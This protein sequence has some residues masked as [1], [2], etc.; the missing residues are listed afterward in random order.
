[1]Q[2]KQT[3]ETKN[4]KTCDI[5][6]DKNKTH[7]VNCGFC[8][9]FGCS[10]CIKKSILYSQSDP[11][12][13]KCN[14][15]WS[16][17]FC[18]EKLTKTFMTKDYPI[19]KKNL[20]FD[21]EKSKI[22]NTMNVVRNLYKVE[23]YNELI[24]LKEI[25]I[26]EIRVHYSKLYDELNEIKTKKKEIKKKRETGVFKKRCPGEQCNGFL[27]CKYKCYSCNISVCSECYEIKICDESN[28][29]CNQD[30]VASYKLIKE[31]TKNCPTCAV[32]IFKI[33]GCDQMW[34]VKCKVAFSWKTGRE[35]TTGTIH[36]PHFYEWKRTNK[37][38]FRNVG[39]ILCGGL[40]DINKINHLLNLAEHSVRLSGNFERLSLRG[41]PGDGVEY[42]SLPIF[43]T[44]IKQILF[45]CFLST[46]HRQ[47]SH[48][49]DQTLNIFRRNAN[50][51][52]ASLD[53]RVAFIRNNISEKQFK[54]NIMKLDRKRQKTLKILHIYE[55]FYVTT[56]ETFNDIFH[57]VYN[58][59]TDKKKLFGGFHR[60]MNEA[61]EELYVKN[62]ENGRVATQKITYN[63]QRMNDILVY[64]NKELFKVSKLYKQNVGF[65]LPSC[66]TISK[67]YNE[68]KFQK[69]EY[70]NT[71]V[72]KKNFSAMEINGTVV[73][74]DDSPFVIK[75]RKVSGE[76]QERHISN[77]DW[78][79]NDDT[80][81]NE[82]LSN[83]YNGLPINEKATNC[84]MCMMDGK[85]PSEFVE[86]LLFNQP[87]K[88]RAKLSA[89]AAAIF[90]DSDDEMSGSEGAPVKN[91]SVNV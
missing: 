12:C 50:V 80:F 70:F 41:N 32:P 36:N 58:L 45:L 20:L 26:E 72:R 2:S 89:A 7:K 22:P 9:F 3:G 63:I 91:K 52:D 73:S 54:R 59:Y 64:S 75:W 29:V 79:I 31:E 62:K 35:V 82:L 18:T 44:R 34:C 37:D 4:N 30:S 40:P 69:S 77:C 53:Y 85:N 76:E 68:E 71:D 86:N 16:F 57:I 21:I 48:F 55:M 19:H 46:K 74:V 1:M 65:I 6:L 56:L 60:E 78:F 51:E 25:H 28:H 8:D 17:E 14:H 39:E 23:E 87:F 5:C 15:I 61:A 43:D 47:I 84:I 11:Q 42:L 10:D 38:S 13:P 90:S 49:Q 66:Y 27:S 88:K 83:G 67:K 33:N 81:Y 24:R